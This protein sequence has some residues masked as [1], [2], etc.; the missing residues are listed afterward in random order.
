MR[1][2]YEGVDQEIANGEAFKVPE[3]CAVVPFR[4]API[5]QCPKFQGFRNGVLHR[6][7]I[8]VEFI[9]GEVSQCE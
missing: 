1:A 7:D 9:H 4:R 5:P 6:I 2:K 3:C 8:D